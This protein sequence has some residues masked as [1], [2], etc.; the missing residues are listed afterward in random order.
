MPDYSLPPFPSYT[1]VQ[2]ALHANHQPCHNK[3]IELLAPDTSTLRWSMSL[4]EDV[5]FWEPNLSCPAFPCLWSCRNTAHAPKALPFLAWW[6]S[7]N[8]EKGS[9]LGMTIHVMETRQSVG[10]A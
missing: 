6:R 3:D 7:D 1:G 9:A 2:M 5:S 4:S 10:C 8:E